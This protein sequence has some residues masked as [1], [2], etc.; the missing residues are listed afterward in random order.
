MSTTATL[1]RRS[2]RLPDNANAEDLLRIH[3]D[4][5]RRQLAAARDQLIA[6]RRRVVAL[7]TAVDNW[8]EMAQLAEITS[9]SIN[10]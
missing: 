4:C 8:V 6:S 7:E 3:T 9:R 10:Y 5:A 1:D 2:S